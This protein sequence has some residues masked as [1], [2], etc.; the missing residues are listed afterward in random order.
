VARIPASDAAAAAEL[1]A[2]EKD[3]AEHVMIVDL[4]RN[5]LGRLA[6]PAPSRRR[7]AVAGVAADGA[8]PGLGGRLH[9]GAG[10]TLTE[11]LAAVF[12]AGS[13][14]GAPKRRTVEIID[15]LEQRARGLY[16]GAIVVL[17]PTGDP[18]QHPIRTGELDGAG[19]TVQSGGGI[20]IDSDPEAERLETWAKVRAFDR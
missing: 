15:E 18:L 10:W 11:L 19:L 4:V 7:A 12:P 8:P 5:D 6:V 20:V 1:L 16:C 17:A 9:A 14:T 3:L 13:I 2:S